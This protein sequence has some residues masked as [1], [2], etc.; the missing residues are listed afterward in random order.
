VLLIPMMVNFW[1]KIAR[2]RFE[3]V[4]LLLLLLLLFE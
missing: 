1:V 3:G 2:T 4:L